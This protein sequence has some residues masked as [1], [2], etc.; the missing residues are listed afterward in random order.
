MRVHAHGDGAP[1]RAAG[2]FRITLDFAR[3][4]R[5][6]IAPAKSLLFGSDSG[7]RSFLSAVDWGLG[8]ASL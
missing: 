1:R 4:I 3:R 8:Q 5:G 2:A 6:A 7:N